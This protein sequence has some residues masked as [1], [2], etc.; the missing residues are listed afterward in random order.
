[1]GSRTFILAS[2]QDP[3]AQAVCG[4][5]DALGVSVNFWEL[6]ELPSKVF[7]HYLLENSSTQC[8]LYQASLEKAV[9]RAPLDLMS[10]DSIWLR[11][12]GKVRV[13]SFPEQWMESLAER[14]CSRALNAMFR[15]MP[16][17]WVNPPEHQIEALLKLRQ[18]DIARSCGLS[19]PETL[20]T[21][22]PEL[23]RNFFEKHDGKVIYKLIDEGS[24]KYFPTYEIVMGMPTLPLRTDD[25]AHLEQ[26][27][28]SLHLFQQRIDKTSDIRVTVVAD[29]LFA[30]EILS[31]LGRGKVD[32]RLDY[33]VPM[34]H[35]QLPDQ[36][37][38][39]CLEVL[40]RLGLTYGAFDL[41][42]SKEGQYF[43]LEVNPAGQWLWME[44][45]LELPISL[46]LARLL[47]G[48]D[49]PLK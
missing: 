39:S 45:E 11:R 7:L 6:D 24:Y 23:V 13:A 26:V 12:P 35:H 3:H 18:L 38:E 46:H 8:L 48:L 25:L 10:F 44:R 41:C 30:V 21:N 36:I 33:S 16:G 49:C 31:Q 40:R 29:K 28:L 34:R 1:M 15:S 20:V 43:F 9:S 22:D 47:A 5:L 4:H 19:I 14:E 27:R 17:L 32:F 2:Q 42:L 37:S